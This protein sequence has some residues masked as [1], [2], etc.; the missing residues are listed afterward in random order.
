MMAAEINFIVLHVL[1]MLFPIFMMDYILLIYVNI[2]NLEN[3]WSKLK[4]FI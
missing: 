3:G 2:S 1:M 4:F